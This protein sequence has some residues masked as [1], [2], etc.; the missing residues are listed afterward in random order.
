MKL[1]SL[2][3]A[4]MVLAT[5]IATDYETAH[6]RDDCAKGMQNYIDNNKNSAEVEVIPTGIG[7]RNVGGNNSNNADN[8]EAV[9]KITTGSGQNLFDKLK[10]PAQSNNKVST[11]F[12]LTFLTSVINNY[13]CWCFRGENWPGAPDPTGFVDAVDVYDDACKA[14]HQG[15]DCITLDAEEEEESCIP[16]QTNYHLLVKQLANGDFT[17]EC[18]DQEWDNW[19]KRRVCLVDI[20]LIARSAK[21]KEQGIE[22]DYEQY[23]HEGYHND[24]GAFDTSVCKVERQPKGNGTG[25]HDKRK[26]KRVC[27][28]DYPYRIWYDENNERG[29]SCCA[30]NDAAVINDYGFAL[31]VGQLY[32]SM[33]AT[34]CDD[35]VVSGSTIC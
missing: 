24:V 5:A 35:K 16:N 14:H 3:N 21:L 30:Y 11:R 32:N 33:S 26:I 4:S 31:K 12:G 2:T 9:Y 13:G 15:F 27:C 23:G 25:G 10:A 18:A 22:P 17:L 28:G 1:F 6:C 20:R 7:A 8:A 19:C 29:I 34:C